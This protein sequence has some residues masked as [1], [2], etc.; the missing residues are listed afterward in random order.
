MA[1]ATWRRSQR[2]H[3][4]RPAPVF[5]LTMRVRAPGV[6]LVQVALEAGL[7]DVEMRQQFHLVDQH[8]VG[9]SVHDRVFERLVLALGHGVHHHPPMLTHR[10]V[11]RIDDVAQVFDHD[12]VELGQRQ[13]TER[14]SHHQRVQMSLTAVAG[15]GVDQLDLDAQAGQP[16]RRPDWSRSRLRSRR[17]RP[18]PSG[19]ARSRPTTSSCPPPGE[20]IRLTAITPA[21]SRSSRL[22]AAVL[23]LS[24]WMRS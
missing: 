23:S 1:V 17:R 24:A 18:D 6:N 16:F 13:S 11:G 10:E 3:S 19:A 21:A 14:R 12:Q 20:P 22:R 9:R 4:S 15:A 5:A 7:V 2:H 8:Q